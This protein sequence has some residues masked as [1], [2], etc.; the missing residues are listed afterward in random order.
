MRSEDLVW[1]LR[2]V[3]GLLAVSINMESAYAY[4]LCVFQLSGQTRTTRLREEESEFIMTTERQR[5]AD[6]LL[7]HTDLKSGYTHTHSPAR[8]TLKV[9]AQ[10]R[11]S[12]IMVHTCSTHPHAPDQASRLARSHGSLVAAI[13][14]I[15]LAGHCPSTCAGRQDQVT[16]N[17][18]SRLG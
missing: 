18:P 17:A 10:S 3:Y 8:M 9:R 14:L 12:M 4:R 2:D 16:Q 5:A 15:V 13:N 7:S 1:V 11:V 6:R